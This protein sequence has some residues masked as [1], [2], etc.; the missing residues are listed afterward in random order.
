MEVEMEP[1]RRL[2]V[3]HVNHQQWTPL[4]I[5]PTQKNYDSHSGFHCFSLTILV[6]AY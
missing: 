3:F 6:H 4:L 1:D 2:F 5:I